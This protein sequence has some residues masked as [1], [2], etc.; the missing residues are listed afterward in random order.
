MTCPSDSIPLFGLRRF[1]IRMKLDVL[2]RLFGADV[3]KTRGC[4][5]AR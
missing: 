3:P 1:A 2:S 5:P 4:I